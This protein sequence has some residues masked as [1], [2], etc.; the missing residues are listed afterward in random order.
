[1]LYERWIWLSLL[2]FLCFLAAC[3]NKNNVSEPDARTL[4]SDSLLQETNDTINNIQSGQVTLQFGVDD[5]SLHS[6]DALIAAFEQ[7][8]PAIHIQV[9]SIPDMTAGLERNEANIQVAQMADVF[10]SRTIFGSNWQQLMLDLTPLITATPG[11][12][13]DDFPP[14]LLT[15]PDSTIRVLPITLNPILLAYNKTL[16][17]AAGLDAPQPG[18]TWEAFRAAAN[19]LT[20]QNGTETVQW[21]LVHSF[22]GSFSFYVSQTDGWLIDWSENLPQPRFAEPDMIAA[23]RQHTNLYLIDGVG[24]N[25]GS[26]TAYNE[27]EALIAAGQVAMWPIFYNELAHY[28]EMQDIGVVPFPTGAHEETTMVYVDGFAI[29][30]ATAHPQA[31]WEWLNFLSHQ[32]PAGVKNLPA[33]TSTQEAGQYWQSTDPQF[34][35]VVEYGLARS[36]KYYFHPTNRTFVDAVTSILADGQS[37]EEALTEAHNIAA[38]ALNTGDGDVELR[39]IEANENNL[40]ENA[41]TTI[42]FL[43][44]PLN[45]TEAYRLAAQQFEEAHPDIQVEVRLADFDKGVNVD[46]D[47]GDAGDCFQWGE[48]LLY[49]QEKRDTIL[50]LDA[51]VQADASFNLDV[52]YTPLVDA[53]T[54]QGELWGLPADFTPLIIEY[55]KDIFDAAGVSYPQP[56]WTMD[57]FLETAVALTHGEEDNKQYGFVPEVVESLTIG[58]MLNGYGINLINNSTNPPTFK[59]NDPIIIEAVRW[60]ADLSQTYGVKPVFTI[61]PLSAFQSGGPNVNFYNE[62]KRLIQDELTGMWSRFSNNNYGFGFSDTDGLTNLGAVSLPINPSVQVGS[63]SQTGY[64]I[65]ANTPHREACWQWITFL[66]TVDVSLGVPARRALAESS[67]YRQRVGNEVALAQIAAIGQIQ[68]PDPALAQSQWMTPGSVWFSRAVAQIVE[69][70]IPIEVSLTDAQTLF[71]TYRNCVI[72][73]DAFNNYEILSGC[74][75]DVDSTIP[76]DWI[77]R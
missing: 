51:F 53:Y 73:N 63:V 65:A 58:A 77:F 22:P 5:F 60:Y 1:M 20:I 47:G 10:D 41:V 28:A 3:Q 32:I 55:N 42:V 74:V 19:T 57:E 61:D 2:I 35:D 44:S 7:E 48:D 17:E 34:R 69:D 50:G 8:N 27:A 68:R 72:D 33:R 12:N 9:K 16:F 49:D 11:F 45:E 59:F 43:P 62:R 38:H 71:D 4:N 64:F 36:F 46:I 23:V 21:G 54:F 52:F 56:G 15:E 39:M 14:N 30:A 66:T 25:G 40:P 75:Q 26:V 37:V 29:S 67:V 76:D 31:A 13:Q 18:W 24:P 70:G 6:Y